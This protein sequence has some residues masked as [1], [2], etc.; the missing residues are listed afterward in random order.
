MLS[1]SLRVF[2]VFLLLVGLSA[3]GARATIFTNAWVPAF[4]GVDYTTGQAD[5]NEVRQQKVFAYR[6]DTQEPSLQFYSTPSNGTNS[7][8]TDGQTTTAFVN[9]YQ[10][11]AAVNANFFSPVST[12]PND[13][14]DLSGLAI[15]LG[16]IVSPFESGR[17]SF[18]ITRSNVAAI[19]TSAPVNYSNIWTAVSGSDRILISGVPQLLSCTSSFCMSN[20]RTAVGY[21][22]NGRYIYL[23]VIDGRQTGWSDGATL[24]ETGQWLQR[25]GAYNGLNLDGGGSTAM[26]K[27]ENGAAVLINKPS[28]GVQR[29]DGNHLGFFALSVGPSVVGQPLPVY[30][31]TGQSAVFSVTAG[32]TTPLKYQ[33]RYNGTNIGSATASSYTRS[34]LQLSHFGYYSV[35]VTNSLGAVTSSAVALICTNTPTQPKFTQLPLRTNNAMR[36]VIAA[37]MGR[38]YSVEVSSNLTTWAVVSNVFNQQTNFLVFDGGATNGPRR[39]YRVRWEAP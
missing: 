4:K 7:M 10:V 15:S 18:V 27:L 1:S 30:A 26:A 21:S 25:L 34:S 22:S 16:D 23:M 24:Y 5:T 32:G 2:G 29:V 11:S 14:R 31:A 17:P 33:W 12:I 9:T 35:V 20:P 6:L 36:L 38:N 3:P 19:I 13:P 37:D 8:E 39:F 28:G